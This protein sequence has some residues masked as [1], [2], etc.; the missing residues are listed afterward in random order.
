MIAA[1]RGRKMDEHDFGAYQIA[2]HFGMARLSYDQV[3]RLFFNYDEYRV[4]RAG[5]RVCF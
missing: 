5:T 2:A 3:Q 1:P 4:V